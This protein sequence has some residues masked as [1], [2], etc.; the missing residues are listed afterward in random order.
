[1]FYK[2]T[3]N[4]ELVNTELLLLREIQDWVS[5]SLW[6]HFQNRSIYKLGLCVF[7]LKAPYL[8][9]IVDSLT[10]N[11]QKQHYNSCLNAAYLTYLFSLWG[12][13]LQKL[14]EPRNMWA[15]FQH[16]VWVPFQTNKKPQNVANMAPNVP[17]KEYLF[18]RRELK[19]RRQSTSLSTLAG[20]MPRRIT[21]S[22]LCTCLWMTNESTWVL[23]SGPKYILASRR[24]WKDRIYK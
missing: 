3:A 6:S 20:N 9:Y 24:I 22:S 14:L 5:V 1:M 17:Q 18:I 4:S 10:L 7:L 12:I 2:I 19:R 21:V 13:A 15:T 16:Y 11:S 8:I 23:V